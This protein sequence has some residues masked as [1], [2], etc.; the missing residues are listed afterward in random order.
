M[1]VVSN[2]FFHPSPDSFAV[3]LVEV[4]GV[5]LSGRGSGFFLVIVFSSIGRSTSWKV[6]VDLLSEVVSL[7]SWAGAPGLFVA[8]CGG[9]SSRRCGP[10]A[11]FPRGGRLPFFFLLPGDL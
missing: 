6:R 7:R 8:C 10:F 3:R 4:V 11:S 2:F 9:S 1:R 5:S